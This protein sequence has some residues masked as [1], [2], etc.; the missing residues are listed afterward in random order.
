MYHIGHCQMNGELDDA[1]TMLQELQEVD[2][3]SSL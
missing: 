2:T 1:R 3:V